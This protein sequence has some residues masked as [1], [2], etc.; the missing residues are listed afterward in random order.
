MC[1][2][3]TVIE[4]SLKYRDGRKWKSRWCVVTKLS[5]VADCLQVQLYRDSRERCKNGPTKA[6]L[7]L[8]GC[9]GMESGFTLDKE[10]HTLAV[11]CPELVL[12]LAFDSRELLIQWKVKIRANVAEEHQFLIQLTHAPPRAKLPTGPTRLHLQDYLF[13]LTAG[14]PPRILGTWPLKELRRFGLVDGKFCFEGGSKC[15]K[16]EGLHILHTNQ[17]EEL[18]QAFEAALKGQLATKRKLASKT[19]L[20]ET[21]SRMSLQPRSRNQDSSQCCSTESRRPL[22]SSACS[23]GGS[24]CDA[25]SEI[26]RFASDAPLPEDF[27]Q[28]KA[29]CKVHYRWPSCM[30]QCG[31]ASSVCSSEV[32]SADTVSL[33]ISDIQEPTPPLKSPEG[34]TEGSAQL[35]GAP[36]LQP[37]LT[38]THCNKCGRHYCARSTFPTAEQHPPGRTEH[39]PERAPITGFS[40]HWTMD[41][42]VTSPSTASE[43]TVQTRPTL[44]SAAN[45]RVLKPSDRASLCSQSSGTS[46]TSAGSATSTSSSEY[47]V[48]RNFLESFYDHPRNLLHVD[49]EFFRVPSCTSSDRGSGLPTPSPMGD[50]LPGIH[51]NA[52]CPCWSRSM[53]N[54]CSR[55]TRSSSGSSDSPL[56]SPKKPPSQQPFPGTPRIV[57]QCHAPKSPCTCNQGTTVYPNYDVPR[58]ALANIYLRERQA[59]QSAADSSGE[60]KANPASPAMGQHY[61]VP[62][63]FKEKLLQQEV[64]V[65]EAISHGRT[66]CTCGTVLSSGLSHVCKEQSVVD[67]LQSTCTCH[68]VVCWAGNLVPCWSTTPSD[69]CKAVCAQEGFFIHNPQHRVP[70]SQTQGG[71]A[72]ICQEPSRKISGPLQQQLPQAHDQAK[73]RAPACTPTAT[74]PNYANIHF[75]ESL[76]LYQ[77]TGSLTCTRSQQDPKQSNETKLAVEAK[78]P[79]PPRNSSPANSKA[80]STTCSVEN[81]PD[82]SG[83]LK[84]SGVRGSPSSTCGESYE[85]MSFR[86]A[87][88]ENL[89]LVCDG[90]YV[91]M[92]PVEPTKQPDGKQTTTEHSDRLPLPLRPFMPYLLPCRE[93]YPEE[94]PPECDKSRKGNKA[95]SS[96]FFRRRQMI[97]QESFQSKT[98]TLSSSL[99]DLKKKVLMRRRSNSADGRQ[100]SDETFEP[101]DCPTYTVQSAKTTPSKKHSL[102]SKLSLRSREKACNIN[103]ITPPSSVPSTPNSRSLEN[104]YKIPFHRSA[105]CL[106]LKGDFVFS[107]EDLSKDGDALDDVQQGPSSIKR[108]SSVPCKAQSEVEQATSPSDSGVSTSL[109]HSSE[110]VCELVNNG[111][112]LHSSLPRRIEGGSHGI[113]RDE[114]REV[115]CS[116]AR[117]CTYIQSCD[118]VKHEHSHHAFHVCPH[119]GQ[120]TVQNERYL[121]TSSKGSSSSTT[122]SDSDYIETMSLCS[123]GSGGSGSEYMRQEELASSGRTLATCPVSCILKPRSAKEY[124]SIDRTGIREEDEPESPTCCNMHSAECCKNHAAPI[125]FTF[126]KT[127]LPSEGSSTD[128]NVNSSSEMPGLNAT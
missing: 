116:S 85:V 5:P 83:S 119:H 29:F 33:T 107:E 97:A 78:P 30:S 82:R 9:L 128:L 8:T 100:E 1:D 6:S 2:P 84:R 114:N 60:G 48:P 13:C 36:C 79:L 96:P 58:T 23:D 77:N 87:P 44:P 35:P 72:T 4:G 40:P 26:V 117:D 122:S 108:S 38:Y 62:R 111:I 46:S 14:V 99:A 66:M 69:D 104:L 53:T 50:S 94:L 91:V 110:T 125:H 20:V 42:K 37:V 15:G 75:I 68:Q 49:G 63:Y 103:D 11:L 95:C 113:M 105:D 34:L 59:S 51:G 54:R 90:N 24:S 16:G 7:S 81:S 70:G 41:L 101:D 65:H 22:L 18:S 31:P 57:F 12:V 112:T 118:G 64:K 80:G 126:P 55:V 88:P 89:T 92:H 52:P 106:K 86:R 28:A 17:T 127:C 25:C 43:V 61:D 98:T 71:S 47:N 76:S 115:Q 93:E 124:N 67:P 10:S 109:P 73:P 19:T 120:Y 102:L 32:E 39:S 123:S 56:A 74:T 21:P 27:F 121:S 45:P 3:R